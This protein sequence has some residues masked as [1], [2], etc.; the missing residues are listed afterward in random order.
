MTIELS[1]LDKAHVVDGN[2]S[3]DEVISLM[4]KEKVSQIVVCD[5]GKQYLGMIEA[6]EIL[7]GLLPASAKG[8]HGLQD[9]SFAG[10]ATGLLTGNLNTLRKSNVKDIM[11][12]ELPVLEEGGGMLEAA[13][14]VSQHDAPLPVVNEKGELLG[15]LGHRAIIASLSNGMGAS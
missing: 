15:L 5:D 8:P 3:V 12:K 2:T 11:N 7:T 6:R 9:L 1:M 4:L 10:D 14:Q 13:L